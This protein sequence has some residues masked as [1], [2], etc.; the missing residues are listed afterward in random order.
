MEIANAFIGHAEKPT[1]EELSAALGLTNGI[2]NRLVEVMAE[3]YGVNVQEW[4]SYSLKA[5]WS[6]LLKLKKRNIL[7]MAP[8]K[9]CFQVA[10]ILGDKAM[11]AVRQIKLPQRV[12]AAIENATR[13]P[14]GTGV[15]LLVKHMAD[16]GAIQKIAAIKLAS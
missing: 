6:L 5:G 16:L 1:S 2:W 8:Y 11:K 3:E 9:E 15:R 10:F 13:Y 14:E 4:T 7:Y 12:T